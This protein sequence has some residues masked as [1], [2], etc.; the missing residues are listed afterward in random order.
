MDDWACCGA[1][2]CI[3][4]KMSHDIML[5][6]SFFRICSFDVNIIDVGFHF[7]HLNISNF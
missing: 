3:D 6:L 1:L 5:Y 2:Q 7:S 4:I